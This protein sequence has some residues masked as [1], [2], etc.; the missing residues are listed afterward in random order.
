MYQIN[1]KNNVS[2]LIVRW[3]YTHI[4]TPETSPAASKQNK[5]VFVSIIVWFEAFASS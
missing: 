4:C 3:R 1:V 5:I 2:V